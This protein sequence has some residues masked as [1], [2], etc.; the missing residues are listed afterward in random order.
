MSRTNAYRIT[1]TQFVKESFF[2]TRKRV[3]EEIK[4]FY[5]S[6]H[7]SRKHEESKNNS[8]NKILQQSSLTTLPIWYLRKKMVYR[9]FIQY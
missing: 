3:K 5:E 9:L 4:N 6:I 7:Y 8:K 2:G 1:D